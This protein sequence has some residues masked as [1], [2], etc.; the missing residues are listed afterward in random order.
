[1]IFLQYMTASQEVPIGP[2]L[3][4]TDGKTA[5]TGLTINNTDIKI[6]KSGTTTLANKNSGGATHIAN[7]IYCITLDA[8]DTDVNG[9]LVI[10]VHVAG[11]LPVRL[12]CM[13]V[14]GNVLGALGGTD[15]L[16]VD[17]IQMN[18]TNLTGRDIGA[19]VLLADGAITAAKIADGAIDLATF[20]A[21]CKT[22]SALKAS[23]E[24]VAAGAITAAAIAAGAIDADALAADAVD[25]I[26]DEAVE[27]TI[28]L[29]EILRVVL[30][31][32]AGKSAGGGTGT[33][34]FRD[35]GDTKNRI[36]ATVDANGNRTAV[37]LD[38]S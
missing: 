30:S 38:A 2:F 25:E 8:T 36:S 27:G 33:V 20:A 5:E 21:D 24:A 14:P 10:F 32:L 11:A 6:W 1:M 3:D 37:T 7:G 15:Y 17:T 18:G 23:V 19:S 9:P 26:L 31:S 13:V 35:N 12:E 4:D 16:Y 29:R 34:T 28:T 22:G